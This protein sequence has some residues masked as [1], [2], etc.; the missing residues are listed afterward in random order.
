ML[1]SM[2][3][4]LRVR[5]AEQ[6]L[7]QMALAARVGMSRDRFWRI[8]NGF[9]EPTAAEQAALAEAVG[10]PRGVVFPVGAAVSSGSDMAASA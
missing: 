3:N 6:R 1:S 5:R 9:A 10:A 2:V 8:E 7:S 4:T